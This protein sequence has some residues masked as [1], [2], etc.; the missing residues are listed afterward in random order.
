[1]AWWEPY[2]PPGEP[3]GLELAIYLVIIALAAAGLL[4][5]VGMVLWS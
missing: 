2:I 4:T 1:M 5:V 3:K